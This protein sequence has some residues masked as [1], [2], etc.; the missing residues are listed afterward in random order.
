MF[1]YI[2]FSWG[3][4]NLDGAGV[5]KSIFRVYNQTIGLRPALARLQRLSKTLPFSIYH[6]E[7]YTAEKIRKY[8][9]F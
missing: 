7:L 5:R 1:S 2:F 4:D 8:F 6:V 9:L 3:L